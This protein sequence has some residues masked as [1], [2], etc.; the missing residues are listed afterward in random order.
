MT[1]CIIIER[2]SEEKAVEHHGFDKVPSEEDVL[3]VVL[4][5]G[6]E[7]DPKYDRVLFY[8]IDY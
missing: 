5:Q 4:E 2:D 6:Y 3:D 7:Y 1:Y 8:P